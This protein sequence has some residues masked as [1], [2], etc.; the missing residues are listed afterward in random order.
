MKRQTLFVT[1]L[2]GTLLGSDSRVSTRSAQ[3]LADLTEAGVMIT[4]ATARTP[5]T[6][7]PLLRGSGLK[8]PVIVMTGAAIWDLQT[9]KYL[10]I[11]T[12]ETDVADEIRLIMRHYGLRPFIYR[13]DHR[14]I[15]H[16]YHNG[17]MSQA[18]QSF[19]QERSRLRLKRLHIDHP[20]GELPI[21]GTVLLYVIGTRDEVYECAAMLRQLGGCTV[22]A[23][24]DIFTRDRAHLE[25]LA[26][27][28]S[29]A[30]AIRDL[31]DRLGASSVTVFGDNLNDI[32][33][34]Q[35]ADRAVAVDNAQDEVKAVADEVIGSNTA[36]SVP[37]YIKGVCGL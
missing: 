15:I 12:I 25:V 9:R 10:D 13:I 30:T 33:M 35:A 23:Y 20:D 27:G 37:L 26:P 2:D 4:A 7:D 6:V 28:V 5:A 36:D 1:D 18:E 16:T 17:L 19:A 32:S 3:L 22:S 34:M 31:A 29:K 24:N 14:G 21:T 11:K 8:L